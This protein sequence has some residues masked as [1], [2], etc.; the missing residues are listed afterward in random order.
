MD[1]SQISTQEGAQQSQFAYEFPSLVKQAVQRTF[2]WMALGLAITGLTAIFAADSTFTYYLFSGSSFLFYGLLIAELALVWFLSSQ[3]MKLSVPVATASFAL[4]SVLNG[5]TLSLIFYIY[6]EAS[7]AS[8]FFVTAGTFG[9]MALFGYVTKRDLS[10]WG[11]LL[12][13]ALIGLIIASVVNWFLAST[14]LMW[15]TTYAGVL[16]FVGLTAYDTQKIKQMLW[17]A[18]GDEEL[19]K[20]VSLIGALGLYLD[21]INLFLYLL[22]IF[23]RRR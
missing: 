1:N 20:R 5:L 11:S 7:I 2:V 18:A 6:T 4:Y 19:S 10:R 14:T 9:A 15:I 3:I 12:Y 23:G 21:F 13:M 22:R 8:T 16:I 17:E